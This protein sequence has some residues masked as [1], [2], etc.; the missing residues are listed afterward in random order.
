MIGMSA[1]LRESWR[2][3]STLSPIQ[4]SRLG[5]LIILPSALFIFKFINILYV[6]NYYIYFFNLIYLYLYFYC[7]IL[8]FQLFL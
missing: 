7:F 5:I 8:Y 2:H 3:K 1:V 6:Y 4:F